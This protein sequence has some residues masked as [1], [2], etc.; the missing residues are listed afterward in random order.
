MIRATDRTTR[1]SPGIVARALLVVITAA[2]AAA[3]GGTAIAQ[4]NVSGQASAALVKSQES[5]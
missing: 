4:V 2:A 1:S 5:V 3:T